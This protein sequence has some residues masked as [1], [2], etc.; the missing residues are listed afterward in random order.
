MTAFSV[1]ERLRALSSDLASAEQKV[2]RALFAS[3]MIAG[4]ETVASLAARAGVSGPTVI[5]LTGK[6]GFR[7]YEDFQR[8]V[9]HELEAQRQSLLS[10]YPGSRNRPGGAL[11][12]HA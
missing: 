11:G 6:L 12:K 5:R 1:A 3:R 8:E 2:A 9:R 10:M 4:L 7:K